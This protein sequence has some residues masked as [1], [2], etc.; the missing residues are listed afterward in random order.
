MYHHG[1]NVSSDYD[2]PDYDPRANQ[3]QRTRAAIV[4]AANALL[5]AGVR[6]TVPEAAAA[7]RVSRAT[8]YRYFPTQ[9]AL[10]VEAAA[11]RPTGTIEALLSSLPDSGGRANFTALQ[12]TAS[13]VMFKEEAAMRAALRTY[14]DAW[15]QAREKGDPAP[16]VRE[17]R[18]MRWIDTALG[19]TLATLP[20]SRARR[21]RA[22][23]A[24]TLGIEPLI[25]MRDVCRLD[26]AQAR[27][28]L[29]WVAET[30]L[31]AVLTESR[32]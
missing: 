29:G 9:D 1:M 8:A 22:G 23:L 28:V 32:D 5:A 15:F 20:E 14:L 30:L 27:E 16:H 24:L 26:D 2:A 25:V 12:A 7:A 13:D 21:L 31:D 3:K 18:R 10:L 19:P 6:P 4:E 17:G 11:S